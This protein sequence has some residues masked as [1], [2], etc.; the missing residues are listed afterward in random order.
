MKLQCKLFILTL[1]FNSV[2][3]GQN[4][5]VTHHEFGINLLELPATT[6]G[7]S[8]NRT[9]NP[10]HSF[11]MGMGYTFNYA[12]SFDIIGFLLSPHYKCGNDGYSMKIQSGPYIRAGF[13]LNA[14][15]TTDDYRYFFAGVYL[16]QSLVNELAEL[17]DPEMPGIPYE[18]FHH[19]QYIFGFKGEIGYNVKIIKNLQS[20][21]WASISL[22]SKQYKELY[23]YSHFI[24]GMGYME[25]CGGNRIFPMTGFNLK[26]CIFN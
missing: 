22:P 14:R 13:R 18:K 15:K 10:W 9:T 16:T 5:K 7:I 11:S 23:G 4:V 21:I 24:P 8:Y 20:E 25:T 2:L 26:Y 17:N 3:F 1:A 6:I 19:L 12:K